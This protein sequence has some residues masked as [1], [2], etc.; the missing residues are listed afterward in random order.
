MKNELFNIIYA[1][2]PWTYNDK[3]SMG[4]RGVYYKYK[5]LSIK[6]IKALPIQNI[7]AE[8]CILFLWGTWPLLQDCLETVKA[9]GFEYKTCGFVWV[10]VTKT[11]PK[12]IIRGMGR[13]TRG[14]SEFVMIGRKGKML[15]RYDKSISQ[16][17]IE[18][19]GEKNSEKPYSVVNKI[20]KLYGAQY[21]K[22]ELFARR[23][24]PGWA[25]TGLEYDNMDIQ[26]FLKRYKYE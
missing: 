11:K 15:E 22:I 9:W 2:P 8:N 18:P 21:R 10:K 12:K 13:Y 25:A 17:I 6:E 14:N 4:N 24:H 3:L 1:D 19:R 26:D 23:C 5:T 16:M 20:D 7:T